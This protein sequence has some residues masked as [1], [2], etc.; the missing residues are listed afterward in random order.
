MIDG[1]NPC[2]CCKAKD[3]ASGCSHCVLDEHEAEC[4]NSDCMMNYEGMCKLGFG[5]VCKASTEYED[6]IAYHDCNECIYYVE[7]ED[8]FVF[9]EYDR[10]RP[11]EIGRWD[12]AC[13]NF[14]ERDGE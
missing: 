11:H 12:S 2:E 1:K 8:V 9:C 7:G 10:D 4:C 13:E 6:D 3:K 14:K 5:K